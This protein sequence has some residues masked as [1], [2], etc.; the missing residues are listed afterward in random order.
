MKNVDRYYLRQAAQ[1]IAQSGVNLSLRRLSEDPTWRG[2]YSNLSMMNGSLFISVI[3]TQFLSKP[4]IKIVSTGI[5]D[6]N[7]STERRETSIAYLASGFMP[8]AVKAAITTN[9][10]IKTLG[11]LI[12]D[13]RNHGW[14][15]N[16]LGNSGTAG[17]WTTRTLT[18]SGNSKIGGTESG[19]DY[20]PS[21][22]G[23]ASIIKTN[24][25]YPG[26]YPGTP[27]SI[28][29]GASNGFSEGTLKQMAIGGIGGSQYATNPALLS[30]PLRG[31]TYVELPSGG[32]WQSMN[33]EGSGLLVVHNSMKNAGLKNLNSGTFKGLVI[34][35]DVV[36][37]HSD[38][39]GALIALTPSPSEGNCIGNGNGRV[40]YSTEAVTRATGSA[41]SAT[42]Q[43]SGSEG[44]VMAWWE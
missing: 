29:G 17:I 27:D 41:G 15:G 28:L 1:N 3:D 40:L 20:A 23:N 42:S 24:Q 19:A 16:F 10:P 18:Q 6:Y 11:G 2:G 5:T 9:N 35:D 37:I 43:G 32:V 25:T 33:I 44:G 8:A 22:P 21:K 13:G 36:H 34:A 39:I 30:T 14:N 12:V 31:V 26:G 38:I 4:A 7:K